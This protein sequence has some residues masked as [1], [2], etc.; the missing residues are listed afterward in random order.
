MPTAAGLYYFV[1]GEDLRDCPPVLLLHG[2]GGAHLSWPPQIRRLN[3]QRIFALDLPG[4]GKSEGIGRQE[5]AEYAKTVVEFMKAVRLS[6]VVAVGISM[7]SAIAMSLA[8]GYRKRV[9]GLGLIGSGAK[10]R[11]AASTLELISKSSTFL[12]GVETIIDS[13]YSSDIDP[14][15]KEL[16]VQQMAETRQAVLYGD[17]LAC[18]EFD[19]MERV[20][21]IHIP[22]LLICGSA[23]RMTPPSRSEY[24]RDQIEGSQLHILGGTG[25][26][27][28]IERPDEVAGLLTEFLDQIPY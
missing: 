19:V 23:D 12:S 21:K 15:V 26:M 9:L 22:T 18:D 7:G 4:H 6:G 20:D 25:H 10:L 14:R 13:S 16:A 17:F 5:I 2:A 1:H 11:V 24:L 3:G 27:A 8:L 28:M